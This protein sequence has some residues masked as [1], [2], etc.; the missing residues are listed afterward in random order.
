MNL[1]DECHDK[2][3]KYLAEKK[4]EKKTVS[5]FYGKSNLMYLCFSAFLKEKTFAN[6]R[7]KFPRGLV[8][9]LNKS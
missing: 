5:Y 7:S 1:D 9:N 2:Y 4:R 8:L 3:A 6:S